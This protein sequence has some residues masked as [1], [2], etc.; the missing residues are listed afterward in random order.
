MTER[1]LTMQA[2]VIREHGGPE[3]LV[4]AEL[5]IPDPLPGHVVIRVRA[6]GLNHAEVYF[7][8]GVW[9]DA[10]E[11]TG[12]ECVGQVHADPGGRFSPGQKVAALVGGMGRAIDGS[13]AEYTRVPETNVV[14][15]HSDLSWAQLAAVPES[16]ATA[17][18]CLRR[19]L[20]L[21][22][23]QVL[24]VRGATSALG[25][26]AVNIAAHRGATVIATTRKPDR[27][28]ALAA[29][30][31]A[32][33]L[34]DAPDLSTKIRQLHPAG[35]D[36]VLDVVGTTTLLD[37]LRAARPDG[38]VCVAGFLGGGEPLAGFDPLLH[39]PSGVH[40]SF[41]ASAFM[42]GTPEYPLDQVPFDDIFER[43]AC[44]AYKAAP[45][46]TF[47]FEEIQ[48]AHRLLEAGTA[49]GKIVVTTP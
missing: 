16:Y 2:I 30:G 38:R 41:F 34:L 29:L 42:F 1:N 22:A 49:G 20:A 7:R 9:G 24:L 15:I 31:A 45:A 18:V 4:H 47:P 13:Y 33:P 17:W 8:S 32:T 39:L 14:A 19:N 25:Q 36:A 43:V 3:Q 28:E 35:A 11:V 46:R 6:F 26:A 27:L 37:S 23:G 5:P 48:S 10:A 12:I 40:L 21:D 44:G